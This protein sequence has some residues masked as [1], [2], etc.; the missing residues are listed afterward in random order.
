MTFKIGPVLVIA[1]EDD[2]KCE[3]CGRV[4]ELRPYGPNGMNVCFDCAMKDEET[5]AEMFRKRLEG[6]G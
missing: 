5:A 1:P 2:G 4:E 3:M 6:G